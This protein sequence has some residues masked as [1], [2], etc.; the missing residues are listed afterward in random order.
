MTKLAIVIIFLVFSCTPKKTGV[1]DGSLACGVADCKDA[2][3][4]YITEHVQAAVDAEIWKE[5]AEK[6]LNEKKRRKR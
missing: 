5:I 2:C 1:V 3:E 4:A 6:C